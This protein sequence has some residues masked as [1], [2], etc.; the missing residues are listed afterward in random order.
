MYFPGSGGISA[1]REER[2][3]EH[4][5]GPGETN[6]NAGICPQAREVSP[7]ARWPAITTSVVM[8]CTSSKCYYISAGGVAVAMSVKICPPVAIRGFAGPSTRSWRREMTR[9][10]ETRSQRRR[11]SNV[12]FARLDFC[13]LLSTILLTALFVLVP[14]GPAES[15]SEPANQ[16]SWKE[17]RQLLRK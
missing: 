2:P 10:P 9:V 14:N 17:G 15:D 3:G 1:G 4:E 6:Q 12:C 13:S 16:M 8:F 7:C 5:T 11:R